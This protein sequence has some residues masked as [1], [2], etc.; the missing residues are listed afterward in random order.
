MLV[1]RH[2]CEDLL[3]GRRSLLSF[4]AKAKLVIKFPSWN[5]NNAARS[6]VALWKARLR[7]ELSSIST[8]ER[9]ESTRRK[10][11]LSQMRCRRP[12]LTWTNTPARAVRTGLKLI[13]SPKHFEKS[14]AIH[15]SRRSIGVRMVVGPAP[16]TR[17]S[18]AASIQP[19]MDSPRE[20][21]VQENIPRAAQHRHLLLRSP[22][23][24][25][26]EL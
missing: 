17:P 20:S 10:N 15:L 18:T 4:S 8:T 23:R 25:P 6:K 5:A 2:A 13:R 24:R 26:R 11:S 9:N 19:D 1:N 22:Y 7:S 3:V 16:L 21:F 12:L 14:S